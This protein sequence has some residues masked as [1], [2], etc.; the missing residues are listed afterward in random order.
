MSS[1]LVLNDQMSDVT[2]K[3]SHSGYSWRFPA[4]STLLCAKSQVFQEIIEMRRDEFPP[5]INIMGV[6]PDTMLQLLRYVYTHE[7]PT[8]V[9]ADLLSAAEKFRLTDLRERLEEMAL[10]NLTIGGACH[11][12]ESL[13]MR[14][15]L[16]ED[17]IVK[18][19]C[20]TVIESHAYV[21]FSSDLIFTFGKNTLLKLLES[22]RLNVPDEAV[23]FWGVWR[24]GR[25]YCSQ[26]NRPLTEEALVEVLTDMLVHIR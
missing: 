16:M 1:H 15:P 5:I 20:M 25:R 13:E 8:E 12:L 18:A 17:C 7:Y 11:L 23:V 2:L 26:N 3:V 4:H 10:Q 19:T 9:T 6:Q 24:W 21:V 22:C 14:E